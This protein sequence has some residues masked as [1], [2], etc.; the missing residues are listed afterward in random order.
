MSLADTLKAAVAQDVT[1]PKDAPVSRAEFDGEKWDVQTA[2]IAGAVITDFDDILR[3]MGIDPA[4]FEVSGKPRISRWQFSYRDMDGEMVTEWRTAYRLNLAPVQDRINLPALY[5]EVARDS[6]KRQSPRVHGPSTVV[7]CWGDVQTGKVDHLGG[8]KELLE[9]LEEKRETLREYLKRTPHDHIVVAD[10]GDIIEGFDNVASQIRTNGLSLMDQ[11]DVAA[12]EFWKTIKLC[13]EF[14]PVDVLSIPSNHC[15][16][17]RGG[18]QIAGL[19]SDDWG[20]HINK[21]LEALN[22]EVG[23]DVNFHRPASDYIEMLEFDIKGTKLGLAHG[24][25]ARNPKSVCDWWGKMSHAGELSCDILLTGHFHFPTFKP[26]GRNAATGRTK[27]HVQCST[28]DNGSA[29][30]RNAFGEDGDPALTVF[31]IGED[32]FDVSGFALL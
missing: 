17:R 4:G 1:A 23:L 24:H 18:K 20:I 21:R 10:V 16:W 28:L 19:P 3:E 22:A 5:A 8:V 27:W 29:W 30:V 15:A 25:Q 11:V 13:A 2:P 32:G 12:V 14:A 31:T 9:R 6:E 26:S 7:V